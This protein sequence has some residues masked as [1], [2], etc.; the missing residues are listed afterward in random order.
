MIR[1]ERHSHAILASECRTF[2]PLQMREGHARPTREQ[3]ARRDRGEQLFVEYNGSA[4]RWMQTARFPTK[5]V[6]RLDDEVLPLSLAGAPKDYAAS[7]RSHQRLR[8]TWRITLRD[9]RF[10]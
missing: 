3:R 1:N 9:S 6:A 8:L 5:D 4:P 7:A 10:E 2:G